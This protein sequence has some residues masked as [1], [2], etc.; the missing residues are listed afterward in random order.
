M[1]IKIFSEQIRE[2]EINLLRS[3]MQ[4]YS[5]DKPFNFSIQTPESVCVTI[6]PE[7]KISFC[8]ELFEEL[9]ELLPPKSFYF[10]Y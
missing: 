2:G 1:S 7:D 9:E 6:N 4:K 5:G 10:I 8:P 3:T